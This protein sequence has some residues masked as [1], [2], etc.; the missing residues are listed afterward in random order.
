VQFPGVKS[1]VCVADDTN[2]AA[3]GHRL[4]KK[5]DTFGSSAGM[6]RFPNICVT[7]IHVASALGAQH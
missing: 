4:D 7:C 3:P 1:N 5:V 6:P 2:A